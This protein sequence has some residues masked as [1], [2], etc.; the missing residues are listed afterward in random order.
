MN[1]NSRGSISGMVKPD[2]GQ[3]NFSENVIRSGSPSRGAV[4]S[5][6]MPSARSSAVRNE[7]ASRVSNPSRT[8]M[9]STTTS[10]SWRSFLSSVGGS[11]SSW[12][13]PSIFTRWNP[14]L[15]SSSISLRYSPFRSRIMGAR[16]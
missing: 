3:A 8:T 4:S 16:R 7:S 13:A 11:S 15:R 2:T 14:C 5:T 10:M 9:R 12:N 6:A 1:E